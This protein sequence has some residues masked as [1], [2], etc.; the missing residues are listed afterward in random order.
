[1]GLLC[2]DYFFGDF[3]IAEYLT[4]HS[5]EVSFVYVNV[6][7]YTTI[8]TLLC[9]ILHVFRG[10]ATQ[11]NVQQKKKAIN[12][13]NRKIVWTKAYP[14]FSDAP[15]LSRAEQI[16]RLCARWERKEAKKQKKV[17]L[18]KK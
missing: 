2:A 4:Y 6:W 11:Q 7:G 16:E 3:P 18:K 17:E 15:N 8:G 9:L 12:E 13:R 14:L 1:M 10:I 5:P